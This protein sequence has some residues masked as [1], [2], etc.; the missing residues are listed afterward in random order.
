MSTRTNRRP[1]DFSALGRRLTTAEAPHREKLDVTRALLQL[2]KQ[3]PDLFIRGTYDAVTQGA[4]QLGFR[5]TC[6]GMS[7]LVVADLA[8][9]HL[10]ER[11]PIEGDWE[12]I[13]GGEGVPVSV[14]LLR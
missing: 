3:K 13:V 4:G 12:R 14:L 10:S 9:G 8:A 6:G 11:R 7:V 5:R 1:I 2:R